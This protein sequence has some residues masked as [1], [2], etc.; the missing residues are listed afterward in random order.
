M[1]HGIQATVALHGRFETPR[2]AIRHQ[3]AQ[4]GSPSLS[5]QRSS[6]RSAASGEAGNGAGR[7]AQAES[8]T[9]HAFSSEKAV[10]SNTTEDVATV[11]YLVYC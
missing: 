8:P 5:W 9:V 7:P 11:I 4:F 3:C 6:I 1:A 10:V 2:R